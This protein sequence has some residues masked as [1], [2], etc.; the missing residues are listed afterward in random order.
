MTIRKRKT[1]TFFSNSEDAMVCLE[2]DKIDVPSKDICCAFDENGKYFLKY[3]LMHYTN[4]L[5]TANEL[6]ND[7]YHFITH[8][9]Y[10][11][12]DSVLEELGIASDDNDLTDEELEKIK[13]YYPVCYGTDMIYW[14]DIVG[15]KIEDYYVET[16]NTEP[17]VEKPFKLRVYGCDDES[18]SKTYM[19][20]DEARKMIGF[21]KQ[22]GTLGDNAWKVMYRYFNHDMVFTN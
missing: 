2:E 7:C 10:T 20:E 11:Y 9:K 8:W 19:T 12:P 18:Y 17:T 1:T 15:K 3:K 22:A 14:T 21:L 4:D 13:N 6:F 16:Y 5:M